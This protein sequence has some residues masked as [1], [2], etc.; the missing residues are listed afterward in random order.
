M[1]RYTYKTNCSG[2][3][4]SLLLNRLFRIWDAT[5][6]HSRVSPR[7]D[8][9][10]S[11]SAQHLFVFHLSNNFSGT[12]DPPHVCLPCL[13]PLHLTLPPVP[14]PTSHKPTNFLPPSSGYRLDAP[15]AASSTQATVH[16]VQKRN[17]YKHVLLLSLARRLSNPEQDASLFWLNARVGGLRS[18]LDRLGEVGEGCL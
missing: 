8:Y 14:H 3:S 5:V 13:P 6:K 17:R 12:S 2:H 11:L 18:F 10:S 4:S 1:Q 15:T 7:L 9:S 16:T